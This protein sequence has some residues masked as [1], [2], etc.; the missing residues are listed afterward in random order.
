MQQLYKFTLSGHEFLKGRVFYVLGNST[1]DAKSRF[2]IY[3]DEHK[4]L[5]PANLFS[6]EICGRV[7]EGIFT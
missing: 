4:D 1:E 3:I 2:E 7:G 5:P 6:M